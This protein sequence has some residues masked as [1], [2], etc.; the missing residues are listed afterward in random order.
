MDVTF[1]IRNASPEDFEEI[2][3][4]FNARGSAYFGTTIKNYTTAEEFFSKYVTHR[5]VVRLQQFPKRRIAGYAEI[6]HFPNIPALPEDCWL[7]W[8]NFHY[9]YY[10]INTSKDYHI[11]DKSNTF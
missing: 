6:S 4:L 10:F 9:W 5:M 11:V 3:S 8:L 1:N 2:K 7:D